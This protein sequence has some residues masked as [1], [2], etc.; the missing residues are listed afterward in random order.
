MQ[1]WK[2][3]LNHLPD[4]FA[5]VDS[6]GEEEHYQEDSV[7]AAAELFHG[8]LM[9]GTLGSDTVTTEPS[10]PTFP[11]SVDYIAEKATE[12]TENELKLI[13]DELEKVLVAEEKEELG[14]DNSSGRASHVST[15]RSSHCSSTITLGSKPIPEAKEA[16]CGRGGCD[17]C[18]LQE[19]LLS[20]VIELRDANTVPAKERRVSLGELFQRT[21]IMEADSEPKS[22]KEKRTVIMHILRKIKK[23][24]LHGA[25]GGCISS[26]CATSDAATAETKLRKVRPI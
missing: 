18:P 23:K 9:I 20:S 25:A 21:K 1:D 11:Y 15:G 19:Y 4:T 16:D 12:V 8:F 10:T 3:S 5:D 13:N 14:D 26:A 6:D 24:M 2:D 7:A 22:E 17:V